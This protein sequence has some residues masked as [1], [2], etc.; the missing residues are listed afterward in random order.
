MEQSISD[1]NNDLSYAGG[2]IGSQ[3]EIQDISFQPN[4]DRSSLSRSRTSIDTTKY[5]YVDT[6]FKELTAYEVLDKNE[7]TLAKDAWIKILENF[8]KADTTATIESIYN[9]I[10]LISKTLKSFIYLNLI[11]GKQCLNTSKLG[12][13]SLLRKLQKLIVLVG[14]FRLA[15]QILA[16][17][18]DIKQRENPSLRKLCFLCIT[19]YS[20]KLNHTLNPAILIEM[21]IFLEY[22]I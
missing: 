8:Y 4:E 7:I 10:N 14:R 16:G 6:I 1:H 5:D 9:G 15:T 3:T 22:A 13:K 21:V 11:I 20:L 18:Q 12:D 17:I 19:L 2:G